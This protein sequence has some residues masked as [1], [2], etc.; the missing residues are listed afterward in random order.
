VNRIKNNLF[1]ITVIFCLVIVGLAIRL[2]GINSNHSFWADEALVSSISRDV[3]VGE[4]NLWQGINAVPYQRLQTLTVAIF[5]KIFGI[6]E[7]GARLPSVLWG[8]VGIIFAYLI[9]KKHSNKWGG[10][11]AA[12]LYTFLQ[13]NL[14]HAT[15]AKPYAAVETLFLMALY[16]ADTNIIITFITATLATLYNYVGIIA[17][18]PLIVQ[19]AFRIKWAYLKPVF[20]LFGFIAVVLF[21]W[22]LRIDQIIGVLFHPQYNW[23]TYL[24]EL[25][26]RQF[27]FISLPAIFGLFAIKDKKTIWTMVLAL[28]TLLL[29]WNFTF[30]SHNI[31]YLLPVFGAL[32]V[33]F[34]VFWGKVGES[35]FHK[36]ALVCAAVA[37]LLF[38]GG[39]KIVRKPSVYYTPNA[40]FFADVQNADY[41]TFFKLTYEKFPAFDSYPVFSNLIDPFTWYAHKTPTSLFKIGNLPPYTELLSGIMVY[42]DLKY[43]LVEMKKYPQGFV[44]VEDWQSILPEDIKEYV[45]KNLKLE[46]RV[47]SLS[48]APQEKWPLELFSWGFDK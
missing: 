3:A 11:L 10:I 34:G 5:F 32:V 6:S 28:A 20:W 13:L 17:F 45:K 31:R 25:F 43:F 24:R 27:A 29:S 38:A 4:V 2:S 37:V 26:W 41:K 15:Q 23:T 16:F 46:L 21:G 42:P 48:V 22:F 12:F 40:D 30:Y 9:A 7:W 39:Y 8:S 33:L 36:P 18:F 1:G 44:V 47:E 19:V 35:I 14:A